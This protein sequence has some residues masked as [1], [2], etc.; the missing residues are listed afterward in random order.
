MP[1][2]TEECRAWLANPSE[3]N[4]PLRQQ[5]SF[6][7]FQGIHAGIYNRL[8]RAQWETHYEIIPNDDADFD[9][10]TLF[11]QPQW[12]RMCQGGPRASFNFGAIID[13]ED[14]NDDY[15]WIYHA[16]GLN[17]AKLTFDLWLHPQPGLISPNKIWQRT[18]EFYNNNPNLQ[19]AGFLFGDY[20]WI[21]LPFTLDAQKLQEEY[22]ILNACLE[23]M[24]KALD[25]IVSL[26]PEFKTLIT[27]LYGEN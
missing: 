16:L 22:P 6:T 5:V 14:E 25:A 11:T 4:I 23:P 27:K 19:E 3:D 8:D 2:S 18:Q 21:H 10:N 12:P 26:T 24:L 1:F 15:P 9:L 20:G 13:D 17:K 7:V